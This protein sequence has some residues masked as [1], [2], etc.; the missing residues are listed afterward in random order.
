MTH[1]YPRELAEFVTNR[2]NAETV[3]TSD[4]FAAITSSFK[5]P[6]LEELEHIISTCYQAGL[7]SE[8]HRPVTFRLILSHPSAFPCD[9][10]PPTGLH[11][12]EF[13]RVRKMSAH[14]LRRLSPAA[15]FHRSLIGI[16]K[17]ENDE[18]QIWGFIQSGPRWLRAIHGGRGQAPPMPPALIVHVT[19]PGHIEVCKGPLT[20]GQL[21]AGRVFGPSM[22]V[23]VSKWLAKIFE[24]VHIE[25]LKLHES[26]RMNART[27]WATLD[28]N[29]TRLLSQHMLKRVITAMRTY[30]HGG[31][32]IIVPELVGYDLLKNNPYI[33]MKYKFADG[34]PRGRFKN[35]MLDIMDS[36]A[37]VGGRNGADG[38][39][40]ANRTIGWREYEASSD[41]VLSDLN[42][43]VFE[44][45]HL[46]AELSAVDGAV[47]MTKKFELLGFGG[48]IFCENAEV[49][50]ISRALD[51]EGTVVRNE[52]VE[53]VGTR[54][55]SAFRL[56]GELKSALAIVVSQDGSIHVVCWNEGRVMYWDHQATVSSFDY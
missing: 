43:A 55:R 42:E 14:E 23:F 2:W 32:L 24:N 6:R 49:S 18:F 34:E 47:L 8:E 54:H 30:E 39:D 22:N 25:H 56:C 44:I 19:G 1:A 10:G 11:R 50:H 20:I 12:L 53:G 13:T 48:E 17:D 5:L 40:G 4:L 28:P 3:P 38:A 46:I 51:L 37:E 33:K 35:L 16:T 7:M 15:S 29:I 21:S 45:S 52:S 31:T 26:R 36:L 27:P 9:Q 41:P